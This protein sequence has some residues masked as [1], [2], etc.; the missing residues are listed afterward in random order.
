MV[1]NKMLLSRLT[2]GRFVLAWMVFLWCAALALPHLDSHAQANPVVKAIFVAGY[3]TLLTGTPIALMNYFN[4]AWRRVGIVPNTT[5]YVIWLSL[6]S[7][8][9]VGFLC[10]LAYPAI[11]FAV[12]R[13]RWLAKHRVYTQKPNGYKWNGW[14]EQLTARQ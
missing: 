10:V 8:A 6:E 7:L 13:L 3:A 1:R 9:A 11:M 2:L 12:A 14:L 4:R 5:V